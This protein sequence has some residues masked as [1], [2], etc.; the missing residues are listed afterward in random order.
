MVRV[1]FNCLTHLLIA[2]HF[3]LIVIVEDMDEDDSNGNENEVNIMR[4]LGT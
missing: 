3:C 2:M 1:I 4:S